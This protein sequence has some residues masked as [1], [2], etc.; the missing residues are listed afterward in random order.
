MSWEE[1]LR[2]PNLTSEAFTEIMA[3]AVRERLG[4]SVQVADHLVLHVDMGERM[5]FQCNLQGFWEKDLSE[6]APEKRQSVC[7]S[8]LRA[9]RERVEEHRNE[10]G[11]ASAE[12]DP[13]DLR[14]VIQSR[15]FVDQAGDQ[16]A[17]A[18]L[19]AH[20][21]ADPLAADLCTVYVL[22]RPHSVAFVS[23]QHL[24]P[25]EMTQ[26]EMAEKAQ[27]NLHEAFE[28]TQLDV[29]TLEDEG[30]TTYR[31]TAEGIL[32]SS[33]PLVPAVPQ[34]FAAR[35]AGDLLAVVPARDELFVAGSEHHADVAILRMMG[36]NLFEEDRHPVSRSLI[37]WRGGSWEA[38]EEA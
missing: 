32:A 12:V 26:E 19:S 37:A 9:L 34:Q 7:E 3:E 20:L 15:A 4:A 8:Y 16:Y 29:M 36:E 38:Y 21:C 23:S 22:D 14:P 30:V 11:E 17:D 1:D 18:G 13:A 5:A 31:L 2:A 25:L 10:R 27:R 6:R 35:V 24:G 33:L 28:Q